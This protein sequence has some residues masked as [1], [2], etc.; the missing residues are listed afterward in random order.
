MLSQRTIV[1]LSLSTVLATV[2]TG[3]SLSGAANTT[4]NTN[5]VT[6]NTSMMYDDT[7]D[8]DDALDV[9][10]EDVYGKDL[11]LVTRYPDSIRSYYVSDDWSQSV[12]YQTKASADDIRAYYVTALIEQ[13]WEQSEDATDYIEFTKGDSNNPEIATVWFTEYPKQKLLEY[14]I[15]YE[16]ALTQ[17][18]L[19]EENEAE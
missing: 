2:A 17:A 19:D 4:S 15:D 12:S 1:W 18:E 8:E 7:E 13:G 9:V 5:A 10:T 16:R 3:C 14:E 11:E 6:A